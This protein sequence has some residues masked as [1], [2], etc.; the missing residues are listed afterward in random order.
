MISVV[1][2]PGLPN[3][4][5]SLDSRWYHDYKPALD[6]IQ[7]TAPL[8]AREVFFQDYL[9]PRIVPHPW[10]RWTRFIPGL[11][12]PLYYWAYQRNASFR[13]AVREGAI[14]RIQKAL[15][16]S[17]SIFL[18]LHSHGNRI[19]IDALLT[20][21]ERK[22]LPPQKHITLIGFAPAYSGV[23]FGLIPPALRPR[24]LKTLATLVHSAFFF[25]VRSDLLSGAPT[26]T[27]PPQ[28]NFETFA[29]R[30]WEWLF[31]AHAAVRS[32]SDVL[33][34]LEKSLLRSRSN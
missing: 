29:P 9:W 30:P 10:G 34:S 6:V 22:G 19:A 15:E 24:S 12:I 8:E 18:I 31:V 1:S 27:Q 13:A 7:K 23:A 26:W 16:H 17:D 3:G 5:M 14:E 2:I 32:R 28:F 11:A 33:K 20:L 21:A 4:F 25:R